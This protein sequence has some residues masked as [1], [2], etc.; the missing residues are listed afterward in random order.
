MNIEGL[1]NDPNSAWTLFVRRRDM[2]TLIERL[3][4][5]LKREAE[6]LGDPYIDVPAQSFP[7]QDFA[8]D[9]GHFSPAGSNRF[10]KA[11]A[12]GIEQNCR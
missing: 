6:K 3:N 10:A 9:E 2:W 5:L 4:G 8:D 7:P 12:P 11:V 1:K